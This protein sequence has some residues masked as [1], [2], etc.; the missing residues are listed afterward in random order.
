MQVC[1]RSLNVDIYKNLLSVV[2]WEAWK[3]KKHQTWNQNTWFLGT[4]DYSFSIFLAFFCFSSLSKTRDLDKLYQRF[5]LALTL[6]I[7]TGWQLCCVTWSQWKIESGGILLL[8]YLR[9]TLN[10][11][12]VSSLRAGTNFIYC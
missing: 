7:I 1:C 10:C 9:C 4:N 8:E 11:G 3:W 12:N 5:V 2:L 6:Y